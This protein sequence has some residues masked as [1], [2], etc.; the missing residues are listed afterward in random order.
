[1]RGIGEIRVKNDYFD[2][3]DDDPSDEF[4]DYEFLEPSVGEVLKILIWSGVAVLLL[5]CAFINLM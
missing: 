3:Y 2:E 5:V 1:V 4:A